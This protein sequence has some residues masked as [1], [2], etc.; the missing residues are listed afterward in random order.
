MKLLEL[1]T[2]LEIGSPALNIGSPMRSLA[3]GKYLDMKAGNRVVDFGCGRGEMLCLWA[4]CFGIS[5][6]GVDTHQPNV[7]DASL[8][9]AQWGIADLLEFRCQDMK[10]FKA[11][12]RDY[13]V[14][15]CMG[16][17]MGFGGFEATLVSLKRLIKPTSCIVVA[18]PFY[19]AKKVPGPLLEYEGQW[20]VETEL[21][22]I[23]RK[24]GLEVGYYARAGRDEWER[25]IF[26]SRREDMRLFATTPLGPAKEEHRTRLHRWHDM[27]LRYRQ[28]WQC[29]AF[30]TLHPS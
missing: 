30:M 4:R 1:V 8:R 26:S 22:D 12:D 24:H 25:Y 5:G 9:A 13:D 6:V 21:F 19:L 16:A 28:Q 29:M 11:G 23:A 27:Y 18:E 7:E 3:I 20:H 2:E 14:A 10:E 17:T 15:A